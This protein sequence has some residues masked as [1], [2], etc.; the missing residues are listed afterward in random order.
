[1]RDNINR[2]DAEIGQRIKFASIGDPVLVAID[3][4]L[5]F[6]EIEFAVV[7]RR[8]DLGVNIGL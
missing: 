1:L 3:P 2:G 8:S 7:N 5:A 4:D 6:L